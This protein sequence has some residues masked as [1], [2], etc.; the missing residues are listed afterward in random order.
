MDRDAAASQSDEQHKAPLALH[1]ESVRPEWIDYN[2]HMNVAYYVLVF[3]HATDALLDYLGLD[4]AYRQRNNMSVFV[5]ETHV[6]YERE[7]NVGDPLN[8]TTQ[9]LGHDAKRLHMFHRMQHA[10]EGY[11]AATTEIMAMHVDLAS[12]RSAAMPGTALTRLEDIARTH[13]ALSKPPQAG[14]VIGLRSK[15]GWI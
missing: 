13:A 7:V 4:A 6:T 14:R 10:R 11:L 2:G 5:L 15:E 9:L 3:D 1:A 8:V 12:R